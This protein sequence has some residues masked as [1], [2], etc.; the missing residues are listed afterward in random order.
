LL[1]FWPF[2]YSD[3]FTEVGICGHKGLLL[4]LVH[5]R[6]VGHDFPSF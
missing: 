6:D 1:K 3:N 2:K 5:R 4:F